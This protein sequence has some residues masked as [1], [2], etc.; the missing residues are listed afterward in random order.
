VE[1]AG[2]VT[3]LVEEKVSQDE[4]ELEASL[5]SSLILLQVTHSSQE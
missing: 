3:G 5:Y 1:S 2:W 4:K